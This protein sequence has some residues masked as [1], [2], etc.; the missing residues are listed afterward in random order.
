MASVGKDTDTEFSVMEEIMKDD[1]KCPHCDRHWCICDERQKRQADKET[2]LRGIALQTLGGKRPQF[3]T[4][5]V[6]V[7]PPVAAATTNV[8]LSAK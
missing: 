5:N 7:D 3:P 2:S 6:Q 1:V 8:I 4:K